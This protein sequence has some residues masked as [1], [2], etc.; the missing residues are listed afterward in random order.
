MKAIYIINIIILIITLLFSLFIFLKCNPYY[1][2]YYIINYN[3]TPLCKYLKKLNSQSNIINNYKEYKIIF[4]F[5]H[6]YYDLPESAKY[7]IKIT[8]EYCQ[9]HNYELL[10]KN[11]Y[12]NNQISP[13]WLRVFDLINLS[14]QYDEN[15]IFI[16]L[17]LDAAI[18]PKYFDIAMTNLINIIE[19]Y[20]KK[21]YDIFIGK[22]NIKNKFINTG[23]MFLK[24]TN[25]TKE[26][27]KLWSNKYNKNNWKYINNKWKCINNIN[28]KCIWAGKEY[29]QGALDYLYINNIYNL[30]DYIKILHMSFCSNRYYNYDSFI[31]HFMAHSENYRI[32][33]MK[34]IYFN[35]KYP[36]LY[37]ESDLYQLLK[38]PNKLLTDNIDTSIIP[39][40]LFQTYFNKEIIPDYIFKNIELYAKNYKYFLLDDNDALIFLNKY[41]KYKIVNK[42]NSL[43]LGA[44]KADLL[45]YCLLYIYG[46]IYIDINL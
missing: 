35:L 32:N 19:L 28:E 20:D 36:N 7:A 15:T 41:F 44:H 25:K 2:E 33:N 45:R 18:N 43:K 1:S 34:S 30:R 14:K 29:E 27:L 9:K 12:P 26:I 38:E 22:D 31:Y 11:H 3:Y 16:Y 5:S 17:D 37:K 40:N 10:I 42:F 21:K 46:G 6:D 4:L 24:N 8:N 23:V 39:N 13:Y